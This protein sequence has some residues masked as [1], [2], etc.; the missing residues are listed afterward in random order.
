M[1]WMTV[2]CSDE[3]EAGGEPHPPLP[4]GLSDAR[5]CLTG[6]G[7]EGIKGVGLGGGRVPEKEET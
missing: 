2:M 7:L 5:R 6:C 4:L 3:G 1:R